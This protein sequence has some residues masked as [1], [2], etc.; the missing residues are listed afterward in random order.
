MRSHIHIVARFAAVAVLLAAAAVAEQN[1]LQNGSME[2]GPGPSAIDP[3]VADKWTE[4]G[5]NVERSPT[6][7]YAPPGGGYSLKAFGDSTGTTAGAHQ[8][9]SGISAGQSVMA[10]VQLYSPSFD[11]LA[12]SGEAGLS[13]EFLNSF[14]GIINPPGSVTNLVFNSSSPADTWVSASIGPMAAPAGTAK[15][16][17][18][19][20]LQ[21]SAGDIAGA[22][23]WDDA[24]LHVNAGPNLLLNGDFETAGPSPGQ[25]PV[26]IDFWT[27]F[28]D[29]EK[30][31][32]VARTGSYSLQLGTRKPYSGLFQNM[33]Q[34]VAGD[35]VH[36]EAYAYVPSVGG[37]NGN[38]RLGIK[39]EFVE[40][41]APAQE[42]LA[43]NENSPE[44]QWVQVSLN[45]TVPAEITIARIV[46][47]YFGTTN[48]SG[49]VYI[50]SAYA[51]TGS[52][53][54]MNQLLNESFENGPGGVNGIDDWTEFSSSGASEARLSCFAVPAE[55]GDC[56]ARAT[57][58]TVA[59][60]YQEIDVIPGESLSI[61]AWFRSASFEPFAGTGRAGV[62]VEWFAGSVPPD[63]DIGTPNGSPNTIG[64][65]VALNTWVPLSIDFTMPAG[66]AAE[67]LFVNIIEKGTATTGNAYIDDC[68]AV[69][70]NRPCGGDPDCFTDTDGDCVVSNAELQC[71]LDYWTDPVSSITGPCSALSD[72]NTDANVGNNHL[73]N[74]LDT[75]ANNCN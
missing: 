56:T 33:G 20:R 29:Q 17:V 6:T 75:W 10:S 31:N 74:V 47:I 50:D 59:G 24:Q 61:N 68:Q 48:T 34:F 57:G 15:V 49:A 35:Q 55:D 40:P 41:P 5:E 25:S 72:W 44:N 13:I 1:I 67:A 60:L 53:P 52:A 71:V 9:V 70:L 26:G 63:V 65:G 22:V 3:Q 36:M 54:G 39:L 66:T 4:F 46:M 42:N 43:F 28:E 16:R 19:C 21:W 69:I 45:T 64:P 8:E 37:P 18:L 38:W 27:G 2:L 62:K 12:G 30:S 32:D 51:E 14:N 23:Y 58:T 73:Q 7:N 11:K